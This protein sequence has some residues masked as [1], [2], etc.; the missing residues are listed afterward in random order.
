ME[1]F[2]VDELEQIFF[3]Y[4]V[5]KC[6]YVKIDGASLVPS[7][8]NSVLFTPAGMHPLIPYLIGMEKHSKGNKLINIQNVVRTGAINKV[9]DGSFLTF[10]ELFGI[11]FIGEYNK[12]DILSDVWKFLTEILNIPQERLYMTY[13]EGSDIHDKDV[14]TIS[15]WKKI[16]IKENHLCSTINNLKGP[17]SNEKICGPNTRIFYDTGK[18][19]CS[20]ECTVTCNCGKYVELWDVVFFDYKYK[21]DIL[22]KSF[23]PSVDMGAGVERM[24]TL[25]QDV[26]TIYDTDKMSFIVNVVKTQVDDDNKLSDINNVKKCRIIADHLRC[27]CFIIGDEISTVPSNKGRGYVLRKILRR[28][29]N[30]T[31]QLGITFDSYMFII[32]KIIDLYKKTNPNLE[33]KRTFIINEIHN[34]YDLYNTTLKK[35]LL[36]IAKELKY[37]ECITN[38]DI[39]ILFDRYGVPVDIIKD[40]VIK[41]KVLVRK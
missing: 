35:N 32:N 27:A 22:E 4:F 23:S 13:F 21:N 17:Y 25:I 26:D 12:Q 6:G 2:K 31:N 34:E 7:S 14:D 40:I 36:K 15:S 39:K 3:D 30:L 19:K 41:N 38:E 5:N 9:G 10:F 8:D 16:G 29:F 18:K 24:A 11:W 28:A 1:Y 33:S 20:H 37:K